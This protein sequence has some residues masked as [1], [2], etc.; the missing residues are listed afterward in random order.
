MFQILLVTAL[1]LD[2]FT[3]SLSCG[4]SGTRMTK[5]AA[6]VISVVC[7]GALAVSAGLSA[8][9]R[10]LIAPETASVISFTLLLVIGL[11]KSFESFLKRWIARGDDRKN[12]VRLRMFDLHF[13]LTVYADSRKADIDENKTLSLREAL[14]LALALSLD[15]LGAGFGWGLSSG[16][17][18]RLL[19]LSLVSN[20]LAVTLGYVVGKLLHK[21][22]GR[23]LSWLGGVILTALA[24]TKLPY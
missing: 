24:F 3:A 13:V 17:Y 7:T 14:Y 12:Q 15:G 5:A 11:T 10:G 4:V 23:D 9:V 18:W 19:A 2:A 22:T 16:S 21:K 1:C 8:A 20:I 6:L